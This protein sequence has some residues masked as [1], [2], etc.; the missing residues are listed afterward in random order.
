M[1]PLGA[2]GAADGRV[3]E[4]SR[5]LVPL[6]APA[7]AAWLFDGLYPPHGL[8]GRAR[9]LAGAA[10]ARRA[11][12]RGRA[13]AGWP[14]E[15][16]WRRS[17][18]PE[19][20]GDALAAQSA[21]AGARSGGWVLVRD[22]PSSRRRR[23]LLFRFGPGDRAPRELVKLRPLDA[24]GL[25]LA[26]ERDALAAVAARL[27]AELAGSVPRVLGHGRAG[28][29]ELLRLSVLPGRSAY[30]EMLVA[31]GSA[32]RLAAISAAAARWL[33][34]LHAATRAARPW[35]PPPWEE[36]GEGPSPA[37]Y[38]LVAG[39]AGAPLRPAFGHGDFWPR[40]LLL[41]GADGEPPAVV[42]WEAAGPIAPPLL[43]LF[44]FP[45]AL[46]LAHPAAAG[47]GPSG[48]FRRTFVADTPVSRAVRSYAARYAAAAGWSAELLEPALRLY[49]RMRGRDRG[50][51][52]G[53]PATDDPR[54]WLRC[55]ARLDEAGGCA[56]SG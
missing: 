48:A 32:G 14:F 31:P 26:H 36:L 21:L 4:V 39:T 27:P 52:A 23:T 16:V 10:A 37:W 5:M 7:A 22:E 9:R 43:D 3:G 13:L 46:G 6:A 29:F 17:A 40:N 56:L 50:P 35:R 12:R 42:D 47:D 45:T 8:R 44:D 30:V 38:R 20:W 51:F 18:L 2:T 19:R 11:A 25:P 33:A 53:R 24:P 49:L 41:A 28:G 34:G 15:R 54:F 1:S 55:E